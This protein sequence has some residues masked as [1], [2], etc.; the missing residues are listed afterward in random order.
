MSSSQAHLFLT[1]GRQTWHDPGWHRPGCLLQSTRGLFERS[2]PGAAAADTVG[3]LRLNCCR[4]PC[5][6]FAAVFF[7]PASAGD[8]T[9]DK[10]A[11]A[12][13]CDLDPVESCSLPPSMLLCPILCK[14]R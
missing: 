13:M 12:P 9:C 5:I 4:P 1:S 7:H 11:G 10:A 6:I 3:L 8:L 2:W 14:L